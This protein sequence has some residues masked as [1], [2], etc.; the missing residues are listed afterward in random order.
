MP[1]TRRHAR[2]GF[3]LVA[4]LALL[5]L[6]T[7]LV[8]GAVAIATAMARSAR[9]ERAALEVE[10]RSHR[11]LATVLADWGAE[12]DSLPVGRGVE[13]ELSASEWGGAAY[14]MPASGRLRIQRLAPGLYAVVIDVRT[15]SAPSLARQR[16]RLLVSRPLIPAS[17]DTARAAPGDSGHTKALIRRPPAPIARW[18]AADLY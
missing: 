13:R 7:A 14:G 4:A 6:S 18:S 8:A 1:A 2:Q 5:A 11:A 10:A 17:L 9:S 15:G 16:L 12:A 3:A